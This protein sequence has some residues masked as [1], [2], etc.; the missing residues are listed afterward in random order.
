MR[1]KVGKEG[2]VRNMEV[3]SLENEVVQNLR[4]G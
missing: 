3:V 1:R 2:A 4:R